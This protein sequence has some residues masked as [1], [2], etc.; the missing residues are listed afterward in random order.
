VKA[1]RSSKW[2]HQ[3]K[4][5]SERIADVDPV[6]A[7]QIV[8]DDLNTGLAKTLDKLPKIV[9]KQGGMRLPGRTEVGF[10]SQMNFDGAVVEPGTTTFGKSRW[11][12]FLGDIQE[13]AVEVPSLVFTTSRHRK[14]NMVDSHNRH[15][16]IVLSA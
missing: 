1:S 12:G 4:S 7:G 14:L 3:F 5:V 15:S 16:N 8:L 10:Y 11:L 6:I 13:A 2:L 9:H